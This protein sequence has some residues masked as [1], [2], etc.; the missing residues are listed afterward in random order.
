MKKAKSVF[1][2][3]VFV[4]ATTCTMGQTKTDWKE[5]N[6]FHTVMSQIFHQME[7]GNYRPIRERSD[8]FYQKALAW[9]Q[10]AIPSDFKN[11]KG[12]K[13]NL[14]KLVEEAKELDQKIKANCSDA[15]IKDELTEM[16]DLFH[17]IAGLCET[18]T[19]VVYKCLM[20]CEHGK[21][22]DKQGKCPACGMNLKKVEI[23]STK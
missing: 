21:T 15:A 22:Y 7:E 10:S 17:N 9:K 6:E 2:L 13:N 1:T 20:D 11:I 8:E 23:Q 5:K 18:E 4:L 16:H 19:A 3:V 12:I 14:A